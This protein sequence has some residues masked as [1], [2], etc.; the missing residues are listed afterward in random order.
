[1]KR[2]TVNVVF[3]DLALKHE[4]GAGG[5]Q[6]DVVRMIRPRGARFVAKVIDATSWIFAQHSVLLLGPQATT[7]MFFCF[8]PCFQRF[9]CFHCCSGLP[10]P[11][12][13]MKPRSSSLCSTL[14]NSKRRR[15]KNYREKKEAEKIKTDKN[16]YLYFS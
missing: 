1:M 9:Q 12:H 11:T 15:R 16:V 14:L 7:I 13:H 10:E 4:F 8:P 2:T 5:L 3:P 6:N